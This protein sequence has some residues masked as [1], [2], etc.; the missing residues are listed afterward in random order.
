MQCVPARVRY[1]L[2]TSAL[3]VETVRGVGGTSTSSLFLPS[4]SLSLFATVPS[5]LPLCIGVAPRSGSNAWLGGRLEVLLFLPLFPLFAENRS[6]GENLR[7]TLAA[8]V[9]SQSRVFT[10]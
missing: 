3:V 1:I 4:P 10:S 9:A 2:D 5:P 7:W 8:Y 6:M